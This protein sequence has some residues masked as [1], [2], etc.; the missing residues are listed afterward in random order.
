MGARKA[1]LDPFMREIIKQF[2]LQHL[3]HLRV[4]NKIVKGFPRLLLDLSAESFAEVINMA[5]GRPLS[6]PF[7]PYATGLNFL[8]A[9]YFIP[10]VGLT[11]FVGANPK[12]QASLSKKIVAGLLAVEV[13]QDAVIRAFLNER[14]MEKVEPY[15]TTVGEFTGRLSELRNKLG[16]AGLKDKGL[17]IGGKGKIK[18]KI[19]CWRQVLCWVWKKTSG[20]TQNFC[21]EVVMST[22]LEVSSPGLMVALPDFVCTCT[23]MLDFL[24]FLG[25]F[26][27]FFYTKIKN[28][29]FFLLL[30]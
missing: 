13:G 25:F 9:S 19:L 26:L 23:A 10:Y 7:D 14:A 27:S 5:F 3:G 21:M 24:V 12:L 17:Q 6:P 28:S 29:F 20:D 16:H 1:N 30:L 18:G 2:G 4:I 8:I 22:F 15:G 11:G